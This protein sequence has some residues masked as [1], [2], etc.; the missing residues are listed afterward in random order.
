[1][2]VYWIGFIILFVGMSYNQLQMR[3]ESFSASQTM[4]SIFIQGLGMGMLIAAVLI[5]WMHWPSG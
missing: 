5:G 1:M 4:I 3:R 2:K